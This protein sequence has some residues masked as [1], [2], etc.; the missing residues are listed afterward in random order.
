MTSPISVAAAAAAAEGGSGDDA[1]ADFTVA[2]SGIKFYDAVVR[3]RERE[4]ERESHRRIH[5]LI[6]RLL[7]PPTSLSQ[8]G[9]GNSPVKGARIRCHYRGKLASNGKQFD[10][11][12][13][14][15]RPLPFQVLRGDDN[16]DK[17]AYAL[18]F[19][20]YALRFTLSLYAFAPAQVGVGQVIKGWDM[21]ILGDDGIPAMK[22]GGKR[23]L[24]IPAALAYGSRGAGGV[25]PPNADLVF[26]VELLK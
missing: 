11:S 15:G 26:E 14:R 4:R 20:L 12:Y 23:T 10:S 1:Y 7:G 22:E 19:T 21:G 3:E 13:D 18:R 8:V 5:S 24:Y 6:Y 17:D 9:S 2:P 16:D 25:I